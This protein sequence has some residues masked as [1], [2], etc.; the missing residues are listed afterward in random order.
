MPTRDPYESLG[1]PKG[2]TGDDVRKAYRRLA[3]EH[4]PDANPG[5]P[6][7]EERFKGIQQAYEI[8]SNPEKRRAY[9]ESSRPA[10]GADAPHPPARPQAAG[11]EDGRADRSTY[12]TCSENTA[13]RPLPEPAGAKKS[14]GNSGARIWPVSPRSWAWT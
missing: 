10:P 11:P 1:V 7:A 12:R 2:A 3:R 4:H 9:D 13:V 14:T 6:T 5:D 8:L